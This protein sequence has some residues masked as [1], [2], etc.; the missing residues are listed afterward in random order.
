MGNINWV[1][2]L[3]A[4]AN[5]VLVGAIICVIGMWMDKRREKRQ[6]AALTAEHL[7][8]ID[9]AADGAATALDA[10]VRALQPLPR[11]TPGANLNDD[12]GA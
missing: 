12:S 5:G 6:D 1:V 8:A 11:R 10:A 2:W 9:R 3:L 7:A 4:A